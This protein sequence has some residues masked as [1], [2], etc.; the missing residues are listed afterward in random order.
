MVRPLLIPKGDAKGRHVDW[1]WEG[2][3][4]TPTLGDN[5]IPRGSSMS[6][7]DFIRNGN[8]ACPYRLFSSMSHV[9]F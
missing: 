8:V 1:D 9:T 3:A 4:Q 5:T 6:P 7:V 2:A